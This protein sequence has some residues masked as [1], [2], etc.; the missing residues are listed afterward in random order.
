TA[1]LLTCILFLL[2]ARLRLPTLG[3]E[4]EQT[5]FLF[6]VQAE[7]ADLRFLFLDPFAGL[8]ALGRTRTRRDAGDEISFDSLCLR[9]D[10]LL[11]FEF[12]VELPDAAGRIIDLDTER[13]IEAGQIAKIAA[14]SL[15]DDGL[16]AHRLF[17]FAKLLLVA[18]QLRYETL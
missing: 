8:L 18:V 1:A 11:L 5:S 12:V 7:R 4:A 6:G 3:D 13:A 17:E 15:H 14:E 10:A 9:G 16:R 2:G